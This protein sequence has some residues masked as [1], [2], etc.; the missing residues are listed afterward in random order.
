LYFIPIFEITT[1]LKT[2]KFNNKGISP[3]VKNKQE[4]KQFLISIFENEKVE[5]ENISYIF[6]KDSFFLNSIKNI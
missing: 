2:I 4:L 6:C 5:F 1:F 3:E